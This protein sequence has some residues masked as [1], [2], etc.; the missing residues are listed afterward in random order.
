MVP[1][2]VSEQVF[3]LA[4]EQFEK[5]KHY[6]AGRTKKP[7]THHNDQAVGCRA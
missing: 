1:G 3:A 7:T 6:S 2:L 5:N 4:Q